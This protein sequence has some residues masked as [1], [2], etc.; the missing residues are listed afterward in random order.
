MGE[1]DHRDIAEGATDSSWVEFALRAQSAAA[2]ASTRARNTALPGSPSRSKK[3]A[4]VISCYVFADGTV[5]F[6]IWSDN[7]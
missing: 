4:P 1:I 3:Q 6:K 2:K 5:C 7:R